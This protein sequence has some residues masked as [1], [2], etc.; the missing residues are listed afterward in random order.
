MKTKLIYLL[1]L[2]LPFAV[3]AQQ[4]P[5]KPNFFQQGLQQYNNGQYDAAI[6]SFMK[7]VNQK[8]QAG[9]HQKNAPPNHPKKAEAHYYIAMSFIKKSNGGAN[10]KDQALANLN[11][12]LEIKPDYPPARL[13]R[14]KI[15]LERTQFDLAIADLNQAAQAMPGNPDALYSLG[16]AYVGVENYGPAV[17]PLKKVAEMDPNNPYAH[18][19]LGLAYLKTKEFGLSEQEWKI[20]LKLCPECPEAAQVND[21]LRRG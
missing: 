18:Y 21:F 7:V 12:A 15:Y 9:P 17:P 19:Y 6:Q 4:G 16:R 20:F 14:G 13:A 8:P 3:S 5:P 11:P 1:L 2:I 10:F